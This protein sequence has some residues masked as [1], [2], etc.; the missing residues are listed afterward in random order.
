MLVD[1]SMSALKPS[2][3]QTVSMSTFQQLQELLQQ[4]VDVT[5]VETLVLTESST[6]LEELEQ[7]GVGQFTLVV[8]KPF[9]ALLWRVSPVEKNSFQDKWQT[10]QFNLTFEP[11]AIATFL[12]QLSALP[13]KPTFPQTI[14]QISAKLRPNNAQIQTEFTLRLIAALSPTSMASSNAPS[15]PEQQ[16]QILEHQV[17]ERT[18]ELH[19]AMLAAQSANRAKSEFLAAMSHELR[20]PLTCIIGMSSTLLRW[21]LGELNQRQRDCLQIIHNSGEHLLELINDILDLSQLEAGKTILNLSEFSLSRLAQQSLK[22]FAEKAEAKQVSL[23]IDLH[24]EPECDRFTADPHRVRQILFNLLSNAIKFTPAGGKVTL[25]VF[26][27]REFATF[28]VKDTGI[29]IPEHQRSLLFQKFQQLDQS[30][31]RQ[32]EGTGLGLALAKQLAELHS[33]WIDVDSTVGVGS[34]FTVRLPA[35]RTPAGGVAP[36]KSD[37]LLPPTQPAGQIVL[38]EGQEESANLIYPM[39][40]AAGYQVV[41]MIE[42]S[43]AISQLEVLQPI[44]IIVN[45]QLPDI[46]GHS[47]I[48]Q[49]RQN[50]AT[51]RVKIIALMG[52]TLP[53]NQK[54]CFLAGADDCLTSPIQPEEVLQKVM[55]LTAVMS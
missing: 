28:Q 22:A 20:T 34:V 45:L 18:Q 9:S 23:E 8:S 32:Y 53:E 54:H 47:L 17:I 37:L 15:E 30:Y 38:I 50:P 5:E 42:G 29:G 40:T 13:H 44:T 27:S 33:G 39:L 41:W 21:S 25:R 35:P 10:C 43:A 24:L 7:S 2:F 48:R 11:E 49:L 4:M 16:S 3:C 12:H 14:K 36:K 46:D 52:D 6:V 26:G 1:R 19:D 31:R 51:K 55:A